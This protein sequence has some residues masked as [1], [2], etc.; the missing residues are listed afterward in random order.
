MLLGFKSIL[1]LFLLSSC[2]PSKKLSKNKNTKSKEI[3]EHVVK[4]P[5]IEIKEEDTYD[6]S[7]KHPLYIGNERTSMYIDSLIGKRVAIV[8]NQTSMIG[9]KHIVDSLLSLG[10]QIVKVFC[11]EH[12]F[13][14]ET[15]AGEK[16]YSII[17]EKTGLPLISLYGNNKK[18]KPSQL[19]DVDIVLFDVQDVGVRFYT[20]ISTLH[21]VMEACAENNKKFILLDR[22]NP[23]SHYVD[24]PVRELRYRSFIG[25][26][27]VPI[28]YG[29]TIGE[30]ALMINGECWLS[31]S[32]H[33]ELMVVP[34]KNYS[35]KMPYSIQ[36]PP[37]PN[38][39]SDIAVSLYPSLCFFEATTVSVGRGTNRPFE[40]FGH[41]KFPELGYKFIPISNQGAKNPLWEYIECNGMDLSD[42]AEKRIYEIHLNFLIDAK[43]YL[44]DSIEF[45]NQPNFFDRLA[46][47]A[48]LRRQLNDGW[49]AKEIKHS[50]KNGIRDFRKIR[51]RYLLYN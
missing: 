50:W 44:G 33:C 48:E 41:P 14:G 26:H 21:Y 9:D 43:K 47:T 7:K 32:I 35:R 11:P 49:T 6:L 51:A 46:G 25:M 15:G 16:V 22:P 5:V 36:T 24:G 23:N 12:G 42:F 30:Y 28:V 40:I 27:P 17:D 39:R 37:S 31:D 13:R 19:A 38:L 29:M 4:E 3:E 18:P 2:S 34:C 1:F 20:Y 45:I 10:V 8:G